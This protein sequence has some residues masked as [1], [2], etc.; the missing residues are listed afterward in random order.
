MSSDAVLALCTLGIPYP[1]IQVEGPNPTYASVLQAD[2]ASRISEFTAIS[3]YLYHHLQMGQYEPWH[4]VADL[5]ECIARIE[6][7]H[8][9]M[10]GEL[11]LKLG[12]DPKYQSPAG[13]SWR[14]HYVEY[15]SGNLCEQL[16]ADVQAEQNAI[17]QYRTHLELIQ[18]RYVQAIIERILQDEEHHLRLF[19]EAYEKH[20]R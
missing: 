15:H 16:K 10:L 18:D 11:I 2:Y 13:R 12:G 19:Q 3:Q 7:K 1:E 6:M 8:L 17:T 5:E 14:G 20:C 9:E 4:E